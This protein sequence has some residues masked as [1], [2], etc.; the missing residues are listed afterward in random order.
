MASSENLR[1]IEQSPVFQGVD[2]D[3]YYKINTEPWGGSPTNILVVVKRNGEVT[4]DILTG[5]ATTNG[6]WITLPKISNLVVGTWYRLEIKFTSN[7]NVVKMWSDL[8]GQE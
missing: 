7:G 3:V 4:D 1:R 2:E 6:N 5:N 8:V